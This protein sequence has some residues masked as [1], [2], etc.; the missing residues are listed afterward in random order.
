MDMARNIQ[1]PEAVLSFG[2]IIRNRT[3]SPRAGDWLSES[4][5]RVLLRSESSLISRYR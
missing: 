2:D 1:P 4:R 3:Y 5:K